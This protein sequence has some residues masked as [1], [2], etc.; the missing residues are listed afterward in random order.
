M[1]FSSWIPAGRQRCEHSA[2]VKREGPSERFGSSKDHAVPRRSAHQ[3]KHHREAG[4]T[5]FE[6]D[7]PFEC[8]KVLEHGLGLDSDRTG[9]SREHQVDRPT[10]PGGRN[11]PLSVR[12]D[13]GR[14]TCLELGQQAQ[15]RRIPQGRSFWEGL[16][17]QR[18][19]YGAKEL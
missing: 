10:V 9:E 13:R 14:E 12:S 18:E 11:R 1:P 7:F 5:L 2:R 15:V 17:P 8:L 6:V 3:E 16:S 4:V 19:P